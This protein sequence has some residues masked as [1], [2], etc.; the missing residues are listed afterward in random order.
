MRKNPYRS[1]AA[2]AALIT[3]MLFMA[4]AKLH[5]QEPLATELLYARST[6]R[7]DATGEWT[8]QGQAGQTVAVTASSDDFDTVV[9]LWSPAGELVAD[10]DDDGS[11][12]DSRLVATLTDDGRYLV[13]VQPWGFDPGGAY[14][15][16][17]HVIAQAPPVE[18]MVEMPE[19]LN[20]YARGV[21]DPGDDG[22]WTFQGRAGQTVVVTASSDD[23]DTVVELR[24]PAGQLI[25][26]DDDGG[27]DTNSRLVATLTDDGRYRV[28]VR[29]YAS[30]FDNPGGGTY[31]VAVRVVE[32]TPNP[33]SEPRTVSRPDDHDDG[34][35]NA[36]L[37]GRDMLRYVPPEATAVVF[38]DVDA[39]V[40]SDIYR[41]LAASPLT[42]D[43][44][45]QMQE[46]AGLDFDDIDRLIAG[47]DSDGGRAVVVL[48]GR[49]DQ[50]T[51]DAL[52]QQNRAVEA[53]HGDRPWFR[54]DGDQAIAMP[55]PGVIAIGAQPFVMRAL[56]PPANDSTIESNPRLRRLLSRIPADSTLWAAGRFDRSELH[57]AFGARL[58]DGVHG[59]LIIEPPD[60]AAADDL[61]TQ[62]EMLQTLASI[63]A[64]SQLELDLIDGFH[65]MT[66]DNQVTLSF[67]LP[68]RLLR[69]LLTAIEIEASPADIR[70]TAAPRPV[71]SPRPTA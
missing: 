45:R 34:A 55:E 62:I 57:I 36:S 16:A 27:S 22:N 54:F 30:L 2:R 31:E 46:A 4:Q 25:D 61:Q 21:L 7:G 29:A 69:E 43:V 35:T 58:D 41:W 20:L 5:A 60:Q 24:S 51:L 68:A 32:S 48:A 52:A 33:V 3:A 53:R 18:P 6:L 17:V 59:T 37:H 56:D 26:D 28:N 19:D 49:F 63:A 10:N 9:E 38:S 8:F 64:T 65:V 23:F 44:L 70:I 15:V 1:I 66:R 40:N 14:E 39:L 11:G 13:N 71:S 47:F 42:R 50:A 67:A 12:T